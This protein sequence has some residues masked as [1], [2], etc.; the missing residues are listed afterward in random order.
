ME[1]SLPVKTIGDRT[2]LGAGSGSDSTA[3]ARDSGTGG[4]VG[5][6][7]GLE[8]EKSLA[9]DPVV[10]ALR[11]FPATAGS[12]A[13]LPTDLSPKLAEY[14]HG[15]GL[16]Q[17]YTHQRAAY[18]LAKAGKSFVVTT[19]TAS[20][21]TLCYNL[22]IL[23]AIIKDTDTRAL[24]LFPTKALAQDQ[25]AELYATIEALGEDIATFT[26]DGDT[27]Q[28]ARKAIRSKA[29]IVVTNPDMLHKGILPHHT[30][31]VK[32]FENLKYVVIDELHMN[33]GVYGSHVGNVLRRLQRLCRF[34][35]SDPQFLCSSATIKN[36]AEL[37]T[38]L[39][40]KP[41]EW[42]QE[43]GAPRGERYFAIYNPPVVNRQ[44]GIRKSAL[45]S[46]RDIA[47]RFL[48]KGLQTI[49][50]APSRLAT[51]VLVTYLK[52]MFENRPG[53]EGIIR[54]YR[55]GYLPLKRREIERGLRDGSVLGVVSTNALELGIDIGALDVSVMLSY[56]G[57]VAS[58][59]QQAGRSGRRGSTSAAVLVLNSTPL[60][61]FIG[62]NPEYFF[63]ASAEEG[64]IN[65]D[66]L[67]I[68]ISHIKCAAF[69]LPFESSETFGSENLVEI[70][71]FLET[72]G[73][74]HK[75]GDSWHW[76]H[77]SYPADTVSLRS[78]SS[79]NFVIQDITREPK[80]VA[81]VDFDSAPMMVHEK[82][83]YML[84]GRTYLVHKYDHKERR[85][86]IREA[87]VDYYT[88]AITYTKVRILDSFQEEPRGQVVR[89]H[90]EVHVSQQIVGFKKIKFYTNENVG[91]GELQMPQKEMHTTSY[92][93]TIPREVMVDLPFTGEE[94][95][96][97][98]IA[99]SHTLGQLAS[100]FLMCDRRDLG[101][102]VGDNGQGEAKVE[103]GMG[104]VPIWPDRR[105]P[106]GT[107]QGI[108]SSTPSDALLA[109]TD[110]ASPGPDGPLSA[111]D[112]PP[113]DPYEPNIFVYDNYPGG[114][115]LSEPL[116]RL[117]DRLLS[118]SL[119]L[120]ENCPCFDGCPSCVGP[121][122]EVGQKGKE[123][124]LHLL[125][126]AIQA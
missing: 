23:D 5:I 87:D 58:T 3:L 7:K 119:T 63:G 12:Y 10:V 11:Y 36:P 96:D 126:V 66:N 101:V 99:L 103:R 34:Y 82:A 114:I 70:L 115:G 1:E 21:K 44:L 121:S 28:D 113:L 100:L 97:G 65:P 53:S 6:L 85:A 16:D 52:D 4:L 43:S 51:E 37:A 50:F 18:D 110:G 55:G 116:Y 91:S 2:S 41:V 111:T 24:Y 118:E 64:R 48:E 69:E 13:P 93:L 80:I 108:A 92:W 71:G 124:A 15:R 45:G 123:V 67:H 94:K 98:V 26:Y 9:T 83:V 20:G 104:L 120:I 39:T 33:R 105:K 30:K 8:I 46:A 17:L 42:I 35:G 27:P 78:V 74:V 107:T 19:P 76:T 75:A 47:G 68:L 79:D 59:W 29:H 88:D 109:M 73:F 125:R 31:W 86:H 14:L 25:L 54:G 56:P 90:G 38:A 122:G 32:L 117:H 77:E 40:G 49:V 60:N 89:N 81:E 95:R 22:P 102:A 84:E 72:Q 57:T 106:F 112:R 62:R 61:Q